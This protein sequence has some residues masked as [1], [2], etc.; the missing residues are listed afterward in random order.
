MVDIPL[1]DALL[2]TIDSLKKR[3][4]RPDIERI[5]HMLR[6]KRGISSAD[7]KEA[8]QKLVDAAVVVKVDYKGNTS[9]RN[10]AK[11]K[12]WGSRYCLNPFT[13]SSRVFAAVKTISEMQVRDG[14]AKTIFNPEGSLQDTD[15]ADL[16]GATLVQITDWLKDVHPDLDLTR[17]PIDIMVE[18]EVDVGHL[19]RL[20][21]GRLVAW[22]PPQPKSPEHLSVKPKAGQKAKKSKSVAGRRSPTSSASTSSDLSGPS[23]ISLVDQLSLLQAE[24]IKPDPDQPMDLS[25]TAQI[26]RKGA[27]RRRSFIFC[28][29]HACDAASAIYS[30]RSRLFGKRT[31][32]AAESID[33]QSHALL[34]GGGRRQHAGGDLRRGGGRSELR[35]ERGLDRRPLYVRASLS[36][37]A[38]NALMSHRL[39]VRI[40]SSSGMFD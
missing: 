17:P 9:Y 13:T 8:L 34:R 30:R 27:K 19:D 4:A 38:A 33:Q 1:K 37:G 26:K 25:P 35:V 12:K 18:R 40:D 36:V 16:A 3:K 23:A 28:R 39:P 31:V 5:C 2:E 24:Q 22:I 6:R 11:W 21:D 10:V 14:I 29:I 7:T 20:Q 32:T 15:E